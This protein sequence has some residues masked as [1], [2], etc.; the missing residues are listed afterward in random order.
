M[1]LRLLV[2]LSLILS[3]T[4]LGIL[5]LQLLQPPGQP[6]TGRASRGAARRRSRAQ[7]AHAGG[8]P[9]PVDRHAI[10]G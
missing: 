6:Q 3:V 9:P 4:G 1:F 8:L 2:I 5:A 7:A 10:E